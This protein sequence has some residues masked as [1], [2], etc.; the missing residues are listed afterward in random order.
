MY[1]VQMSLSKSGVPAVSYDSGFR[2][3]TMSGTEVG[4]WV[5]SVGTNEEAIAFPGDIGT[6]GLLVVENLDATNFVVIRT[7]TGVSGL[8]KVL[9]GHAVLLL[10]AAGA[11]APFAIADTLACRCRFILLEA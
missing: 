9:P 6:L 1:R 11:T 7:G 2:Q 4:D 5:Q 10:L 3:F 8:V